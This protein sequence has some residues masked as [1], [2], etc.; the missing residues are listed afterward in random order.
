MAA[1]LNKAL[2]SRRDIRHEVDLFIQH[3]K[4]DFKKKS[5]VDGRILLQTRLRQKLTPSQL[6]NHGMMTS[7]AFSSLEDHRRKRRKAR[8][9]IDDR[10][11]RIQDCEIKLHHEALKLQKDSNFPDWLSKLAS[12]PTLFYGEAF[13][14]FQNF[15]RMVLVSL[16]K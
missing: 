13:I 9:K 4:E 15:Q 16:P 14:V 10:N 1:P 2:L 8:R 5:P 7:T 12:L 6:I 11:A 3:T